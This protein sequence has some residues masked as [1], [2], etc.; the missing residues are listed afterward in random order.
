MHVH[1]KFQIITYSDEKGML[2]REE[3]LIIAGFESSSWYLDSEQD[4][5]AAL[6]DAHR[7]MT[8]S[9]ETVKTAHM[10]GH[11][12]K[13]KAFEQF[14]TPEKLNV[15]TPNLA[16]YRYELD[17]QLLTKVEPVPLLPLP[18]VFSVVRT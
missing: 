1:A 14:T 11:Q 8:I 5:I 6:E 17:I 9:V 2:Q 3:K 16:T 15:F 18:T 13:D 4:V 10:K 12:D 7:Q